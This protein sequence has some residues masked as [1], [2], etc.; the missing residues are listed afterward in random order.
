MADDFIN[1][2]GA[3][4][5]EMNHLP[6]PITQCVDR[7]SIFAHL[8]PSKTPSPRPPPVEAE[9]CQK[10]QHVF[11]IIKTIIHHDFQAMNRN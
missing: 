11:A 1:N 3:V 2:G 10:L 9:Q 5:K 7:A 8:Q 4:S 6:G